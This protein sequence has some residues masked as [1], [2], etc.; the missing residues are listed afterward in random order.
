MRHRRRAVVIAAA[1]L[2]LAVAGAIA[3]P[4]A[5]ASGSTGPAVKASAAQTVGVGVASPGSV[6]TAG[7]LSAPAAPFSDCAEAPVPEVPGRGVV[8]FFETPPKTLPADEDPFA[9]NAKVSIYEVYGYA[10]VRWNTYDL[11]CGSDIVRN[12]DASI[13]TAIGNWILEVPT[14]MVAATGAVLDAAFSPDF[15]GVFDPLI[16]NV[17]DTL[18]RTVF[19]RWAF[20]VVAALGLLLI[21]RSR[22]AS[23]AS[24][25]GAI[26][27]ALFVM[28][29][30]T[31]V[32][33]W[34]LVAGHAAD[35]TVTT[36]LSA[37][38]SGLNGKSADGNAG[39]GTEATSGMHQSLLYESWLGGTFGSTD[40][41]V[42]EKYGPVIFDATAL[43]WREAAVM[44]SDPAQ[45][46][47]IIEAK[48]KKFETAAKEI[49]SADPDAYE[50]L[51]GKRSDSRVGYAMLALIATLCT[52]PF[53][54]IAGLLVL[55]ALIIVRFGVMLFP[56]FATLGLFPTMRT[57]V[58]GI[59]STVA[60]AL[61]NA[62]VF[63]IG[64]SVTVLGMGV[65]LSPTSATPGWLSVILMLLLTIVMWVALR[66]FRRLTQMVNS[67][68]NHF[69]GA[70]GGVSTTARGAARTSTRILTGALSTFL[71]VSTAQRANPA[72]AIADAQAAEGRAPQRI[73][74]ISNYPVPATA[75]GVLPAEA[76]GAPA[77]VVAA[78]ASLSNGVTV[79]TSQVTVVRGPAVTSRGEAGAAPAV[80]S[81]GGEI[82]APTVAPGSRIES[83]TVSQ[84]SGAGRAAARA[85]LSGFGGPAE[86][87][88]TPGRFETGSTPGRPK[89]EFA[90]EPAAKVGS[91]GWRPQD[92]GAPVI[93]PG[94][95]G[96][97]RLE[98][99]PSDHF[100]TEL[101]EVFRP[102][103]SGAESSSD[104]RAGQR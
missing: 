7:L 42:A 85:A 44:Q 56:A 92:D 19:E 48:E 88:D 24:S 94:D 95:R 74:G 31:M 9:D 8:G 66:P 25:A 52:V 4:A 98:S 23:L 104:D 63:G 34:P 76:Q 18:Q 12:P 40:S 37:V 41:D 91:E 57:L 17:V 96:F 82:Y 58:T 26:G 13:G 102:H 72:Q 20:V 14:T 59:G 5:L 60:A 33:R 61:I 54:F 3:A 73:E 50:Y 39:A 35:Q 22:Q 2:A 15:L 84:G 11:G 79:N 53:L 47:K 28:V 27:W 51:T 46:R 86:R 49:K 21:W 101:D 32:F 97:Q 89:R 16:T 30:V 83:A 87:E 10:G 71:G 29:L 65:L 81:E 6:T 75:E 55:G 90:A 36:T 64:A 70:A 78:P 67:R 77:P 100:E 68:E 45:G 103:R 38:S 99:E 93:R 62:M 43:T 80:P 1:A 69:A